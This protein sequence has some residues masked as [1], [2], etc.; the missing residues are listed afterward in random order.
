VTV[1]DFVQSSISGPGALSPEALTFRERQV[2]EAEALL[3][4]SKKNAA[5]A[6]AKVAALAKKH[7][8]VNDRLVEVNASLR[9]KAGVRAV[10][11]DLKA[12]KAEVAKRLPLE[13]ERRL[14]TEA[15]QLLVAEDVAEADLAAKEARLEIKRAQR[16][17]VD[18]KGR[19][20]AANL[21][22]ALAPAMRR[23]PALTI[24]LDN[25]G[26]IVEFVKK[27]A[28]IDGEIDE[29]ANALA[30]DKQIVAQQQTAGAHITH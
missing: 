27:L 14:L 21:W 15:L 13:A 7:A 8:I 22:A 16:A 1:E 25:G 19:S 29:L 11:A 10:V 24:Q 17:W 2:A 30:R 9:D 23:D 28:E 3:R 18:A 20:E 5:G 6:E 4:A 26:V 12:I